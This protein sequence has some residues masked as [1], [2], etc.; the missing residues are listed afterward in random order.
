MW[1][2]D[3]SAQLTA[4]RAYLQDYSG[5]VS[6]IHRREAGVLVAAIRQTDDRD[7]R[8]ALS[9]RLL[10]ARMTALL[11][12][13]LLFVAIRRRLA[14]SLVEERLKATVSDARDLLREAGRQQGQAF[15]QLLDLPSP[16]QVRAAADDPVIANEYLD[17]SEQRGR[18]LGRIADLA[19]QDMLLTVLDPQRHGR[20]LVATPLTVSAV[21]TGHVSDLPEV[22]NTAF[23]LA[24]LSG[25]QLRDSSDLVALACP[26][27]PA[28]VEE[29]ADHV[30]FI[31]Q[32]A[33]ETAALVDLAA[34][35]GLL[36]TALE[37]S[38]APA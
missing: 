3:E 6:S 12:I 16:E 33:G 36:R 9:T 23:Y 10:Q 28:V 7:Q 20:I 31:D 1:L 34:E 4:D 37:P 11:S 18:N 25:G 19:R 2:E 21:K 14:S 5:W 8:K 30:A 26:T 38:E 22:S 27:T 13:G 32:E 29:I 15:W 24:D 35:V 17:L